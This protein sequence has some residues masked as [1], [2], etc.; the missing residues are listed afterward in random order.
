MSQEVIPKVI[1]LFGYLLGIQP[2]NCPK[3][4]IRSLLTQPKAQR[5][6]RFWANSIQL[7]SSQPI[8]IVFHAVVLLQVPYQN[9]TCSSLLMWAILPACGNLLDLPI[10]TAVSDFLEVS[11][12]KT[13]YGYYFT[14]TGETPLVGC[15]QLLVHYIRSCPVCLQMPPSSA[16]S[17]YTM[18]LT[19]YPNNNEHTNRIWFSL[20][21]CLIV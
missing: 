17:R 11:K 9:S 3:I 6:A 18:S 10:L 1:M 12:H 13:F 15:P 7:P 16:V 2:C 19:R 5:W 20:R 21:F 8:F 4:R 14:Q